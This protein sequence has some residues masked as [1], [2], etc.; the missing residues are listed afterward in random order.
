MIYILH[1]NFDIFLSMKFQ[2][3]SELL[4]VIAMYYA[5]TEESVLRENINEN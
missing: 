2:M 4:A 1:I 5:K 3:S